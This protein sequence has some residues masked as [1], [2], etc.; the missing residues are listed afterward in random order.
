MRAKI[1]SLNIDIPVNCNT[2]KR[3]CLDRDSLTKRNTIIG[4][5]CIF[6]F[7]AIIILLSDALA[8]TATNANHRMVLRIAP[9]ETIEKY[10]QL[11]NT[12][13]T[14]VTIEISLTGDLKDNV[15]LKDNNFIL[16]PS[17]EK[18]VYFTIKADKE[19]TT[20]TRIN[21]KFVPE[22]GTAAAVPTIV[23]LIAN[24]EYKG[25][26]SI[27]EEEISNKDQPSTKS[28]STLTGKEIDKQQNFQNN[29]NLPITI[30]LISTF[31]LLIILIAVYFYSL[32][33]PQKRQ[34]KKYE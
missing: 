21:V 33:K 26:G 9:G 11:Q 3:E 34:T 14:P 7:L 16:Q 19:G 8:I 10:I 1:I 20:E 32:T 24:E 25:T 17:E 12:N 18:K 6:I 27:A 31:A 5:L 29:P 4:N 13:P 30:L 15:K 23:T 28:S 22:K 2:K